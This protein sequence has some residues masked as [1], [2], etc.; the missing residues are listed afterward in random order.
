MKEIVQNAKYSI[1]NPRPE[2][3]GEISYLNNLYLSDSLKSKDIK[4]DRNFY[5]IN[6]QNN[7]IDYLSKKIKEK[8]KFIKL[9]GTYLLYKFE[10]HKKKYYFEG[11]DK[12]NNFIHAVRIY[13]SSSCDLYTF[14]SIKDFRKMEYYVPPLFFNEKISLYSDIE[15]KI[16][17]LIEFNKIKKIY[18]KLLI[19]NF[20]DPYHYSKLSNAIKFFNHSYEQDWTLL[21]ST[22]LFIALESLFSDT[23]KSEINYK[24]ALRASYFLYP[25]DKKR[26]IEIFNIIKDGYDIRSCFVHGSETTN[27]IDKKM[28]KIAKNK[29]VDYYDFHFDFT[30]KDLNK[31]VSMCI[32]KALSDKKSFEFFNSKNNKKE[33]DFYDNLV[34]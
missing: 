18:L 12:V 21:K 28:E 20:R 31:I 6:S 9:N 27:K 1:E 5:I 34:L 26:R 24:V 10:N 4:I 22:L 32:N 30:V 14:F 3:A 8:D 23:S 7:A 29:G 33:I 19:I 17:S 13:K 16:D 11:Q 25:K 15:T 2:T